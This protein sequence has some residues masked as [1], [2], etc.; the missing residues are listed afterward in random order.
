MVPVTGIPA[1]LLRRRGFGGCEEG[2]RAD[3]KAAGVPPPPREWG[4]FG[5]Q[6]SPDHEGVVEVAVELCVPPCGGRNQQRENAGD[7]QG[8]GGGGGCRFGDLAPPPYPSN[9]IAVT[10]SGGPSFRKGGLDTGGGEHQQR[11]K[12]RGC[13]IHKN[14]F[15]SGLDT[16][17]KSEGGDENLDFKNTETGVV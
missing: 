12:T 14:G 10:E 9:L 5:F 13:D 7:C 4:A 2:W 11:T 8:R 16:G 17:A 6:E 1:Q 15:V 3:K